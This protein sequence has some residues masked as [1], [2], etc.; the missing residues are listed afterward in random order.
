[1]PTPLARTLT[2]VVLAAIALTIA[3][4]AADA[5]GSTV[6]ACV[7]K[8]SG[9]AKI[10]VGTK[11][12]KKCPKG[13][14]KVSWN[15]AGPKGAT[16]APG[17]GGAAGLPGAPGPVLN[18]KDAA[19]NVIGQYVGVINEGVNLYFVLRDGGVFTYLESGQLYPIGSSPNFKTNTCTGTAYLEA[20]GSTA[21]LLLDSVG[22]TSR[23]VYR[24]STPVLGPVQAW[25]LAGPAETLAA[26]QMYGLNNMGACVLD[27]GPYS[28]SVVTLASVAAPPDGTGILTIG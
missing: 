20:S 11:A 10:M 23:V 9:A 8:H 2:S 26:V 7:N 25:K 22:G 24:P 21:Q 16:G 19:G 3:P 12:K 14:T 18:V 4:T 6:T 13:T 17:A 5:A 28:G 27:G 15:T 1:M